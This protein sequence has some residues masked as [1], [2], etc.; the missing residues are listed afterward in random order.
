M[1]KKQA[2]TGANA[3]VDNDAAVKAAEQLD[4]DHAALAKLTGSE[5]ASLGLTCG[6]PVEEQI[7]RAKAAKLI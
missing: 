3:P 5:V 6:M 4:K 7:K 2:P 1:A